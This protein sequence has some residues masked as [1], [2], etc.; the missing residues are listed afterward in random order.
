MRF[1]QGVDDRP[2]RLPISATESDASSCRTVKILRSMASIEIFFQLAGSSMLYIEKY[3][4]YVF[5]TTGT[6]CCGG[7]D[8]PTSGGEGAMGTPPEFPSSPNLPD[9]PKEPNRN[10][11]VHRRA[12]EAIRDVMKM[13]KGLSKEQHAELRDVIEAVKGR[14]RRRICCGKNGGRPGCCGIGGVPRSARRAPT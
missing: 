3:R 12:W 7:T 1:Q 13:L 6:I 10:I 14:I 4:N 11:R 2:T 9:L 8:R 5:E